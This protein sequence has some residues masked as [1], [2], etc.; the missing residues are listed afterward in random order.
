MHRSH[1]IIR[2]CGRQ[3]ILGFVISI[4]VA[5]MGRSVGY[6]HPPKLIRHAVPYQDQ[7]VHV[8]T[9]TWSNLVCRTRWVYLSNTYL[10]R[11]LGLRPFDQHPRLI[12]KWGTLEN[13][14]DQTLLSSVVQSNMSGSDSIDNMS[15]N[16]MLSYEE[17]TG[18]PLPA[19][20]LSCYCSPSGTR[21]H[22]GLWLDDASLNW[23]QPSTLPGTDTLGPGFRVHGLV[24]PFDPCGPGLL[25]DS[26]FW[27]FVSSCTLWV[28][29]SL[30][31]SLRRRSQRCEH[32][33]YSLIGIS[34]IIC[35]ECGNT[36][37]ESFRSVLIGPPGRG[38]P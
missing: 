19:L 38:S 13:G 11:V 23:L 5:L 16:P 12:F 31:R 2:S 33:G 4:A 34:A 21:I 35:P 14:V 9:L 1:S 29:R 28:A 32:C 27:A 20:Q 7:V 8:P 36:K 3:L 26:L 18:F 25:V 17:A 22:G 6:H 24:V 37:S 15:M 30:R 10:Q